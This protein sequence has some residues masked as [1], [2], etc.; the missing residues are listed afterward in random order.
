MSIV[1]GKTAGDFVTTRDY[2]LDHEDNPQKYIVLSAQVSIANSTQKGQFP[3]Y[4]LGVNLRFV[5]AEDANDE[6]RA[7]AVNI[8]KP[9]IIPEASVPYVFEVLRRITLDVL[10]QSSEPLL[11]YIASECIV[12]ANHQNGRTE[13]EVAC[14][15]SCCDAESYDEF[16]RE[17]ITPE[18]LGIPRIY[19]PDDQS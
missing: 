2:L 14:S 10:E 3:L 17:P 13:Y 4:S 5:L 9:C 16:Q 19:P 11:C 15:V 6:D 7:S 8:L 12:N 1:N 18:N